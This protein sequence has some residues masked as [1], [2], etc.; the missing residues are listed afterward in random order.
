MRINQVVLFPSVPLFGGEG[1]TSGRYTEKE[2]VHG[3]MDSILEHMEEDRIV[4]RVHS[5]SE[6]ILPN[7]LLIH[8]QIGLDKPNSKAKCN[9]ATVD[10]VGQGALPLATLLC[11]ALVDWGKSYVDFHH[12][13][14]N[15]KVANEPHYD[16]TL[17]VIIK[18]FKINGPQVDDYMRS[19]DQLG[20]TIAYSIYEFMLS[21]GEQPNVMKVDK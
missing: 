8:C 12:K 21:R 6:P 9:M 1:I 19:L 4:C 11:E 2:A 17:G 5:D 20:K 3:Y 16:D 7:T 18:P 10:F 14:A 13:T 15:P